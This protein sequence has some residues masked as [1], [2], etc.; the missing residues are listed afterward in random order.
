[1]SEESSAETAESPSGC[2]LLSDAE[3]GQALGTVIASH[4]D[5][6]LNGCLWESDANTQ[7][8]L[9]VYAGSSVVAGT[10]DAQKYLGT[11]R[12]EEV[13]GL[14]ESAQWKGS[15][16]LVACTPSAVIR[17]NLDNSMRTVPEDKESLIGLARSV[18]DRL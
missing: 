11:G 13:P 9:D 4:E 10:C 2:E 12:E 18:L 17:F 8:M 14:G 6:G 15:G 5:S 7:L 1:M 16:A 3:V